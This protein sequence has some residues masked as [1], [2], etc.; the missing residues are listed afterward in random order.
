M[1]TP[2]VAGALSRLT[3]CRG[4]PGVWDISPVATL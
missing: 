1:S 4:L 2:E 3:Y